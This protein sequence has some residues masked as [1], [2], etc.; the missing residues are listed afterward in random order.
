MKKKVTLKDI[1]EKLDVSVATV[2]RALKNHPDIS[3]RVKDQVNLLVEA[4]HYRPN[5]LAQ[6]F[7]KQRSGMIGVLVPKIVHHYT[8]TILKG[9]LNAAHDA[10][11]QVVISESGQT[12]DDENDNAWALL[13]MG[14]D[15]LLV[16]LSNNT[17]TTDNFA[18][19]QEEGYPI[20][21]FDKVPDDENFNKICDD[22]FKGG[23]IATEHL[24][25]QGYKK[26][27]H[28]AGQ[29]GARNAL[30]RYEGYL[31]ALAKYGLSAN[32]AFVKGG[33]IC[34]EEEGFNLTLELLDQA[35]RPD[36]IFTVNDE[37]AI[38]AIAALRQLNYN[39][40]A[41]VGVAGYCDTM[42]GAYVQPALTTVNQSGNQIGGMAFTMLIDRINE[43]AATPIA[44]ATNIIV[45]RLVVREFSVRGDFGG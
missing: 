3:Q 22:N 33:T 26:I 31:S 40:P 12:A 21:F 23:F 24:I 13:N 36:A 15:G 4:L 35:D 16:S 20:V 27:A 9:I 39:V 19:M 11:Y 25:S 29:R 10:N 8:T 43:P 17:F 5:S 41:D 37:M 1:A 7:R 28:L 38:G 6:N 32:P 14:V 45:P 34:N 30:P 42:V 44:K 18:S 2:S